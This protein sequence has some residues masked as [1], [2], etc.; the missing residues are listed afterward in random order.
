[1]GSLHA[2]GLQITWLPTETQALS[3]A[4]AGHFQ[5]LAGGRT[6]GTA[7]WSVLKM[8]LLKHVGAAGEAAG[9][10]LV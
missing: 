2:Q 7:S 4:G 10:G 6:W 9:G 1:M 8:L 5:E 3:Q